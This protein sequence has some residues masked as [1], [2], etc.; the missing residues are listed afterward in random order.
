MKKLLIFLGVAILTLVVVFGVSNITKQKVYA[1]TSTPTQTSTT[2]QTQQK[3]V[4]NDQEIKD[5]Q[6]IEK[7][8]VEEAKEVKEIED[9][10]LPNGG[11]QDPEG[12]NV[13]HQF[14]GV[15]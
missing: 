3:A 10:N 8:E 11:H 15:E 5:D 12:V 6:E 1:Q 13:D 4:D 14:E 9:D 7:G 2:I